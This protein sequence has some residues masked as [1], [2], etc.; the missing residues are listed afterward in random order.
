M[1]RTIA[2]CLLLSLA[3]P[4]AA[5]QEVAARLV[6]AGIE[7]ILNFAPAS[8]DVPDGTS[9]N[10]VDLASHLERL[11][12]DVSHLSRGKRRKTKSSS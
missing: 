4:A 12:F 7:G 8:L 6:A 10:Q 1:R 11:S 5:A 2:L 9:V 3:V